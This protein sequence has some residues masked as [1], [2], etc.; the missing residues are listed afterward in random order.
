MATPLWTVGAFAARYPRA[1]MSVGR[2]LKEQT[3]ARRLLYATAGVTSDSAITDSCYGYGVPQPCDGSPP[4]GCCGA[5][6]CPGTSQGIDS[7]CARGTCC[8]AEGEDDFAGVYPEAIAELDNGTA[9]AAALRDILTDPDVE[10]VGAAVEQARG[11]A[12]KGQLAALYAPAVPAK[13][14]PSGEAAPARCPVCGCTACPTCGDLCSCLMS[15]QDDATSA[16]ADAGA[17]AA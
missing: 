5:P 14:L 3:S 1:A 15:E 7:A 4:V 17:D 2:A 16:D 9:L 13:P 10:D 12:A 6:P 11:L 8:C